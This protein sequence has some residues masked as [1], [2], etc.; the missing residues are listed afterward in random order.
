M[1]NYSEYQ[2]YGYEELKRRANTKTSSSRR[3]KKKRKRYSKKETEEFD[4]LQ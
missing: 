4:W 1:F 3:T 2:I